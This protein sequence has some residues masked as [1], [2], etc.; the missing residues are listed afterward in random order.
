MD[1][2]KKAGRSPGAPVI[3][4]M[5]T[6]ASDS[7]YTMSE[8]IPSY[9]ISGIAVERNDHREHGRDERVAVKSFYDGLEFY[10]Q[11]LKAVSS[12]KK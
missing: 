1:G 4:E 11:F 10:Y 3:P 8:N 2:P 12:E 5:E 7:I 9:G 6:G